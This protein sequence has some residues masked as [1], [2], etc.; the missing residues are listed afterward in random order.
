MGVLRDYNSIHCVTDV[1]GQTQVILKEVV[2]VKDHQI[3]HESEEFYETVQ[4]DLVS[5]DYVSVYYN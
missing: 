4:Q 2:S 1:K 5:V 3:G